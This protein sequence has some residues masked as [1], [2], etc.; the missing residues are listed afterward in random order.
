MHRSSD[1]PMQ[2]GT[3]F[4]KNIGAQTHVLNPFIAE[5]F[6]SYSSCATDVNT[7]RRSNVCVILGPMRIKHKPRIRILIYIYKR[8]MCW[9]FSVRNRPISCLPTPQ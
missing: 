3:N 1:A 6:C 5:I 7:E 9:A 4:N 2:R 8:T